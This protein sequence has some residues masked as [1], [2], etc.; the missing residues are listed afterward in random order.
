MGA[1]QTGRRGSPGASSEVGLSPSCSGFVCPEH[2]AGSAGRIC[3]SLA[4][5]MSGASI[6]E[7]PGA[8]RMKG[9]RRLG[10]N[11]AEGKRKTKFETAAHSACLV[12]D[13]QTQEGWQRPIFILKLL[14][15][16]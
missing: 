10:N 11:K 5:V 4:L 12:I 8:A 9:N 16:S 15:T 14:L 3:I 2:G 6:C 13:R 1:E 7:V